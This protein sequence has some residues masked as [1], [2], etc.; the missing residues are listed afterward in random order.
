MKNTFTRSKLNRR[1][2]KH[3]RPHAQQQQPI[4]LVNKAVVMSIILHWVAILVWL[5]LINL[6][7]VICQPDLSIQEFH[8]EKRTLTLM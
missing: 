7:R 8:R 3:V 5:P 1:S 2:E 4:S 6:H